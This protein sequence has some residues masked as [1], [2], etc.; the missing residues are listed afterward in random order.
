V[1]LYDAADASRR[2]LHEAYIRKCLDNFLARSNVIH[3]IGE[4]YTGPLE[5][6][7]FW[8]DTIDRWKRETGKSPLIAL[9]CTKDVQDAILSDPM[10]SRT[11]SL[12]D[13]RYWWIQANGIV[14]APEGG[15]HLAP[16]QHA[17]QQNPKP[18]SFDQVVRA[19]REYRK[20]YPDK[21]AIYSADSKYGWAVL[22][23]GG[24]LPNLP[25]S[26]DPTLLEAAPRMEIFENSGDCWAL[27][28]PGI[29]YL[30]Y[31]PSGRP[32]RLDLSGTEG[33]F[34]VSRIDLSTGQ[35][36]FGGQTVKGRAMAEIQASDLPA[37]LWLKRK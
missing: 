19:I 18:A 3:S 12:I 31:A 34:D 1:V 36:F 16:R 25:V 8:L 15:K 22:L 24:S 4:E 37:L 6:V 9:S 28:E 21:A 23:G 11:V 35:A 13:I 17:R 29:Q 26:T 32:T 27:A 14:Y 5:F 2:P 7:Q 10:R 20:K 30:V 33:I